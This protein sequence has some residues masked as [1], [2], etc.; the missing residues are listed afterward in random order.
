[1]AIDYRKEFKENN[2]TVIKNYF[3][4]EECKILY[5]YGKAKY[6][7]ALTMKKDNYSNYRPFW[8]GRIG[9]GMVPDTFALY[10]DVLMDSLCESMVPRLNTLLGVKLLPTYTYWRM[11]KNGDEL[12][13][14]KDRPSCEIST[15]IT[16]GYE[17]DY[18]WPIFIQGD[19]KEGTPGKSY[20]L[21]PGDL[22]IY[23]GV[24]AEHWREKFTGKQHMQVFT[25]YNDANGPYAQINKFD[26]RPHLGLPEDYK[27]HVQQKKVNEVLDI[28]RSI[29]QEES[30]K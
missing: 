21:Y 19:G 15:T 25:H 26:C 9:D 16:V 28:V 24:Y 8:D 11:Y 1:M 14:H 13:R 12:F 23:R 20:E 7:T 18:C 3:T 10:G 6:R 5:D 30:K 29:Q 2:Y 17:S 4:K 27:D 22:L